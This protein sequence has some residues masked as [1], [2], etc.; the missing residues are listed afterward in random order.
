MNPLIKKLK[1]IYYAFKRVKIID[2]SIDKLIFQCP[3]CGT[4]LTTLKNYGIMNVVCECGHS[5]KINTGKDLHKYF[6]K[7]DQPIKDSS[8][9]PKGDISAKEDKKKKH[10]YEIFHKHINEDL[11]TLYK[12]LNNK[13]N[14]IE[15]ANYNHC[16]NL[17]NKKNRIEYGEVVK[18]LQ[19]FLDL[20]EASINITWEPLDNKNTLS[21]TRSETNILGTT[22]T[23]P[24]GT[25]IFYTIYLNPQKLINNKESMLATIAHELTHVYASYNSIKL[26]SPDE[27]RGNKEYNEQMT[28]LLGIVL[29]MGRLM[30]TSSNENESYDT[31]YLTR[32]MICESYDIWKNDFLS[33]ENKI[34]KVVVHCNNC[35]QKVRIPINKKGLKITCPKCKETF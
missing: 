17:L 3:Q 29:G 9:H 5:T 28:D 31:G 10:K 6:G 32:N 12:T 26:L 24:M 7:A 25:I 19:N 1:N 16:I 33:G 8:S 21:D 27:D 30:A 13:R 11:K 2:E 15:Q 23:I 20:K 4:H 18:Y 22:Y 14:V 34:I 35:N